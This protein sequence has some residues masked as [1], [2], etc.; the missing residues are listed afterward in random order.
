MEDTL[1]NPRNEGK[2]TLKCNSM[3]NDASN[4]NLDQVRLDPRKAPG[5]YMILC[6]TNDYR[7]YGETKDVSGRIASH[8]KNLRQRIHGNKNLQEDWNNYGESSFVF[9]ILFIGDDWAERS[10]RIEKEARLITD[11]PQKC[12]NVFASMSDRLADLNPFYKKKHSDETKRLMSLSKKNIPNDALGRIISIEGKEYP[13]I[14]EASRQL[15]H[16]RKYIR[17]CVNSAQYKD[18]FSASEMPN[19]YPNGSRGN[20]SPEKMSNRD[21]ASQPDSG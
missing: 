18:W 5:L 3:L 7:Y 8:K 15:G 9:T 2:D 11:H 13:S 12:Y 14:A 4:Q 6:L 20:A 16:S 19:D 21:S 1:K 10:V 17:R